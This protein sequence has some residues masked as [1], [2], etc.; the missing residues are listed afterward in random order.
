MYHETTGRKY[1]RITFLSQK[2]EGMKAKTKSSDN[3]SDNINM[4][5]RLHSKTPK[6]KLKINTAT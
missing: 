6:T 3:K 1:E 2:A 5:I 4:S